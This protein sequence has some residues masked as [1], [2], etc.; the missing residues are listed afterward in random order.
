[1]SL[2]TSLDFPL[3][4]LWSTLPFAQDVWGSETRQEF[5]LELRIAESLDDFRYWPTSILMLDKALEAK[6]DQLGVNELRRGP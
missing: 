6:D 2:R 3:L 1:M 5:R 4:V